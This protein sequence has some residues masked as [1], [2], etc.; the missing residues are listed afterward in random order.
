MRTIKTLTFV[1]ALAL[2]VTL[3]MLAG[4]ST[5]PA[6]TPPAAA[7]KPAR[8]VAV[9]EPTKGN[10]VTGVIYFDQTPDGLHIHGVVNNLAPNSVHGFHI[11]DYGDLTSPDAMAAGGHFNPEHGTVHGGPGASPHMAGELGNVNADATGTANFD[12][13]VPNLSVD[14]TNPVVGHS[15]VVH[16]SADDLTPKANPGARIG[17]GVIGYSKPL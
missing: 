7:A 17:I 6:Q 3:G 8:A 13:T 1:T 12:L 15:V 10:T 5:S 11:H 9:I 2:A 4:T 16:V 14:G